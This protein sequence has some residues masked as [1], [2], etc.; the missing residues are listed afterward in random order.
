FRRAPAGR[1]EAVGQRADGVGA[2][3]LA[4]QAAID[5]PGHTV[6]TRHRVV[7]VASSYP[8]FPGDTIGTFMQPIA[9]GLAARGHEIHMVLPWAPPLVPPRAGTRRH[10]SSLSLRSR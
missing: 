4:A 2:D 5:R 1:L 6:K 3:A 9:E 7:M 8:R 10:F